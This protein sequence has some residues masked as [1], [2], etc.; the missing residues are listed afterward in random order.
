MTN[1]SFSWPLR[2]GGLV[3]AGA[4]FVA[5]LAA[6]PASAGPAPSSASPTASGTS[7]AYGANHS[8]SATGTA[9][10]GNTSYSLHAYYGWNTVLTQTNGTKG[11]FE[12]EVNRTVGASLYVEYCRPDCSSPAR[13]L[14][15]TEH[16]WQSVVGFANMTDGVV[17]TNG[18]AVPG[19]ALENSSLTQRGNLTETATAL[20]HTLRGKVTA[21]ESLW[22]AS[23]ART[24]VLFQPSLGLLPSEADV[25]QWNSSATYAAT[26]VW[27]VVS[28]L[29]SDPF[30]GTRSSSSQSY[31][32]SFSTAQGTVSVNGTDLG[33][34]TLSNGL[35][36]S[37]VE[38]EISGPFTVWEGFILV[39]N[40]SD[41][42]APGPAPWQADAVG[43]QYAVTQV[44]DVAGGGGLG[45]LPIVAS[46]TRYQPGA[47]DQGSLSLESGVSD[48]VGSTQPGGSSSIAP[49]D[50]PAATTI[51]A[52]PESPSAARANSNCLIVQCGPSGGSNLPRGLLAI[53]VIVVA[54]VVAA[55]VIVSRQ[56]PRKEPSSRNSGLYPPVVAPAPSAPSS[57]NRGPS[58]P[59]DRPSDPLGNLW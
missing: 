33:P 48:S 32:G 31:P 55:V 34:T 28:T 15:L 44:I 2:R 49:M 41:L 54:A 22:V 4:L 23:E 6:V 10:D 21:S 19:I 14:N 52:E 57:P 35:S 40:A 45:H 53:A 51:Q 37:E 43:S 56:P 7:W 17:Y 11:S 27:S 42:M 29:A 30:I 47:T 59:G 25:T 18:A 9:A 38:L 3:A 20:V 1:R 13:S 46:A 50:G 39:P 24:S 58:P 8:L 12:V 16:V 26:G 36:T 5:L